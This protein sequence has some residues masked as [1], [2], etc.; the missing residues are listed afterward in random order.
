MKVQKMSITKMVNTFLLLIKQFKSEQEH[1]NSILIKQTANDFD[2]THRKLIGQ[3]TELE[4]SMQRY[5]M[6]SVQAASELSKGVLE[7]KILGQTAQ[8]TKYSWMV[9]GV[10]EDNKMVF[11]KI[12]SVLDSQQLKNLL[13]SYV[14]LYLNSN[15]IST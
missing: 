15:L 6:L 13:D 7:Q 14:P 12:Y 10:K 1:A 9:E 4:E 3:L 11:R 2:I 5:M 8:M